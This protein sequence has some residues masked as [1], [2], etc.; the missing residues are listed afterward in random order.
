MAT[1]YVAHDLT[2]DRQTALKVL[3]P[4]IGRL[5]EVTEH[6]LNEARVM[7]RL[8]G[9]HVA[10]VFDCGKIQQGLGQ[11]LPFMVLELLEGVDL[12]TALQQNT[13]FSEELTARYMLETCEGL[14]EAHALGIVHR[15]IKPENLFLAQQ[16]DGS[17]TVKLLD[18][19][20][21]KSLDDSRLQSLTTSK[22]LVGSPLYMSPEQMT[23]LPID[24]RTDIW[25]L[26]AVMYE[27]VAGTPA[28]GAL[29]V[30]EI[31]ARVLTDPIPDLR[32]LNIGVS[33]QF[34]SVV[35]RCLNRDPA[36]RFQNVVELAA[37]LEPLA[38]RSSGDSHA[39]R[40]AAVL[41][42][43]MPEPLIS[44]DE[45]EVV[46][47]TT[48]DTI[49]EI[50]SADYKPASVHVKHRRWGLGIS[51]AFV[52]LSGALG[53]SWYRYP[54]RTVSIATNLRNGIVTWLVD[55]SRH[56]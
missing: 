55:A 44:I 31:C 49:A 24:A 42:V 4:D 5:S 15:D 34:A 26:G 30:C 13:R 36:E 48:T 52:A 1:I 29:T 7:A 35:A 51:A 16:V 8:R 2:L 28:F 19:G 43:A 11:D 10:R 12:L 33:V 23:A 20:I 39:E 41:G 53:Y 47:D 17:H 54:D 18:F 50:E 56:L 27:C 37:A 14:A 21:S 32:Q 9:S 46:N 3:R 45:C 22:D 6:F 25:A 40:T 38:S